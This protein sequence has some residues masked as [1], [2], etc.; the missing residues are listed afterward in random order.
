VAGAALALR[1]APY[2]N[3]GA[4]PDGFDCS[5]FTRYVFGQFGIA[6][7]RDTRRQYGEGR[8]IEMEDLAAGDLVFFSTT[9][10]GPSHVAIAIDRE[11]FVHAP[12]SSG[13][14]RVERMGSSYWSRRYIGARRLDGLNSE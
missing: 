1:G 7:P 12:S 10:R 13:V 9:A 2:R 4:E 3:G 5:G 6:L 8:S 14:V 11:H